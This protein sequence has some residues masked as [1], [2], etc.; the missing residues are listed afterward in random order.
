VGGGGGGGGGSD[1]ET[2]IGYVHYQLFDEKREHYCRHEPTLT[3]TAGGGRC[4]KDIVC[5]FTIIEGK[6]QKQEE[7]FI[8]NCESSGGVAPFVRYAP[9]YG[10]F[11]MKN[12]G[13]LYISLKTSPRD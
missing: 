8:A 13:H 9:D 10:Y 12:I 7:Y 1:V 4:N 5:M 2:F 3:L 6:F 11:A